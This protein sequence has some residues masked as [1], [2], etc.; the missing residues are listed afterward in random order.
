[1]VVFW[2]RSAL[3]SR[4]NFIFGGGGIW[5][6]IPEQGSGEFGQKFLEALLAGASQ[7][8]SHMWRLIN[9]DD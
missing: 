6:Q 7:I 5:N 9:F 1:M 8:V 4:N 2:V 3:D